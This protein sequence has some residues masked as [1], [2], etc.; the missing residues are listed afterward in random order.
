MPSPVV[1]RPVRQLAQAIGG[2]LAQFDGL[3]YEMVGSRTGF[4]GANPP[5]RR[6]THEMGRSGQVRAIKQ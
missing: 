5:S 1:V 3:T 2:P 4:R 6:S